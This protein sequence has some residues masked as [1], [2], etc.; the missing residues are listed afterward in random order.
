MLA[1][2]C[3]ART[4]A[5]MCGHY[6]KNSQTPGCI[7]NVVTYALNRALVCDLVDGGRATGVSCG[8]CEKCVV[9]LFSSAAAHLC[10]VIFTALA[11][12]GLKKNQPEYT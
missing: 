12:M 5:G 2:Q 7:F 1:D 8:Q 4:R 3:C 9:S 6:Q 10:N 11:G